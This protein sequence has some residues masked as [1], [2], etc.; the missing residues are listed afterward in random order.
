MITR[1]EIVSVFESI[2][3]IMQIRG[4]EPHRVQMYRRLARILDTIQEDI[5]L[6]YER[7]EL[8][9]ISGI[10]TSTAEKIGELIET[11]RCEY[12]EELRA[13]I[14]AGVLDL[15]DVKQDIVIHQALT[16]VKT[17]FTSGG[18][19]TV[20]I[21]VKAGDTD[22]ILPATLK[23]ALLAPIVIDGD[24]ASERLRVPKGSVLAMEIKVDT[25]TAGKLELEIAFTKF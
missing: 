15:M 13:S 18:A 14:P 24:A 3:D 8:T 7:N 21:G 17:A 4:D 16:K 5:H 9:E 23:G 12:Y 2:A 10:G 22:A 25:V 6:I 11:G 1:A 20:E 19:V